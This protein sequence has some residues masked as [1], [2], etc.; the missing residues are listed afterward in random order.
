MTDAEKEK[1]LTSLSID[2]WDVAMRMKMV[3]LI[4]WNFIQCNGDGKSH[5][6]CKF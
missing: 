4:G 3:V 2:G 6:A 5:R 1:R